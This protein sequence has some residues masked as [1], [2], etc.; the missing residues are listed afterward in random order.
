MLNGF[1]R[2]SASVASN[3]DTVDGRPDLKYPV[4]IIY[5]RRV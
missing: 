3:S 5:S 2:I 1:D 4:E